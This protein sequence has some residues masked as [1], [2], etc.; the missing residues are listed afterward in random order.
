MKNS[1]CSVHLIKIPAALGITE[2]KL[3]HA[4]VYEIYP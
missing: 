1:V 3:I 4:R 2:Y